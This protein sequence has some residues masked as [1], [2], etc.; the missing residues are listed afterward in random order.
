MNTSKRSSP[1]FGCQTLV[2]VLNAQAEQH[3]AEL[4]Y[5]FLLTGEV[6]GET[7]E[8]T[9][10]R[11]HR[12]ARA[13]AALLQEVGARGERVLLLYGPGPEFIPAFLGCL[14]AGAVAVPSY[15]PDPSR[16]ERTLPRLTAIVQDCEAHFVLTTG[17]LQEMAESLLPMA[18]ELAKLRWLASDTVVE[19][20]ASS[21]QA[22][23]LTGDMLAFLQYT[24]GSTG[25]PK[26]VQITHA[27]MLHNETVIERSFG[28]DPSLVSVGWL[29]L[30]HDMGLIGHL[31]QPLYMGVTATLM[32]PL[33]FLQRPVRWLQAISHFRATT[34]GGPNFAYELCIRKVTGDDRALLDLSSWTVAF[35]GA[36]PLRKETLE[37]FAE[38]FAPCGFNRK[39]FYPC[40][41]LAESTLMVTGSHKEE[42][43]LYK[44]V[45]ADALEQGRALPSVDG[46]KNT[47]MLVSSGRDAQEQRAIIVN[48]DSRT[49]CAPGEVG[50]IWVS[51]PSVARGYWNR[52]AETAHA[53][54]ARLVSGE[55]PFL[56]TGDLGFRDGPELFVVSRMKDLII[57]RGRNLFPQDLERTMEGSH[58]SV[59]PGCCAAFS[60]EVDG[61][62]RL[63]IVAEVERR[64]QEL[65]LP[66]ISE[67]LRRAVVEEYSIQPYSVV[68]LE[69]RTIPKTSSG[70]IQRRACRSH[71]LAG[72][73]EVLHRVEFP[74]ALAVPEGE[75]SELQAR[76]RDADAPGQLHLVEDFLRTEV[77]R[78][79]NEDPAALGSEESL[80]EELD[81][82]MLVELLGRSERALG[83]ALT[84]AL[85]LES[86]TLSIAAKNL[87]RVWKEAQR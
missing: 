7:E 47:R 34:S 62:E 29:P 57:V 83:V 85:L 58:P 53:F 31:L 79:L 44:A 26:G 72:T 51:G 24:S 40:Y 14:Y 67:H 32:S 81:S 6:G 20:L 84:P 11:L 19:S 28:H 68:L 37:R 56:R 22:V 59:R 66:E 36:E 42:L 77:A 80:A 46:D 39:A 30:F 15:P 60:V 74:E 73:G 33:A 41:G 54:G 10:A 35:N 63:V 5:R 38:V 23:E 71:F 69:P 78:F 70:K 18:P 1:A 86:S 61:Q 50:E 12:Q 27:N 87:L 17:M 21:Y 64:G 2:E 52:P 9:Y 65:A 55:G 3:A 13:I 8:W 75:V 25:D 4:A 82:L 48:P 45:A 49:P 43:P 76:L 16:I